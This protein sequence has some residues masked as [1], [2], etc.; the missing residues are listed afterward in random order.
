[1][2]NVYIYMWKSQAAE[3]KTAIAD[4]SK[5]QNNFS[6]LRLCGSVEWGLVATH[7]SIFREI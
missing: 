3:K 5:R 1:M 6:H 2:Y 4:K 7:S